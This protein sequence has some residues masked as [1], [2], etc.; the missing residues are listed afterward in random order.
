MTNTVHVEYPQGGALPKFIQSSLTDINKCVYSFCV[1]AKSVTGIGLLFYHKAH[2]RQL[3]AGFFMRTICTH[4]CNFLGKLHSNYGG[5]IEGAKAHRFLMSGKTN[6]DQLTT[7]K[8]GL[9]GGGYKNHHKEAVIM[10][11][12]PTQAVT[13][14][15]IYTFAIAGG[16]RLLSDFKRIRTVSAF[17]KSEQEARHALLGLPIVFV[18][19]TPSNRQEITA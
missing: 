4:F 9:F 19:R 8:I 12:T 6:L 5:L 1:A 13:T 3:F 10:T 7:H 16:S 17:A 11:T 14:A 18:S 2:S 15:M